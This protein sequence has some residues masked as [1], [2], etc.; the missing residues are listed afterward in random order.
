MPPDP[1][2]RTI[3]N[4]VVSKRGSVNRP[5]SYV[6]LELD[7]QLY[8]PHVIVFAYLVLLPLER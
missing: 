7:A 3:S 2:A 8:A 1:S 5:P 4:R 6:G